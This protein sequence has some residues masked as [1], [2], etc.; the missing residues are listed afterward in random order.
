MTLN[1][2][3]SHH[4]GF[5]LI[6]ALMGVIAGLFVRRWTDLGR[7]IS[8]LHERVLLAVPVFRRTLAVHESSGWPPERLGNEFIALQQA[9]LAK[10]RAL[11]PYIVK[12]EEV[13]REFTVVRQAVEAFEARAPALAAVTA[14]LQG[15]ERVY[16]TLDA[17]VDGMPPP[18]DGDVP[19]SPRPAPLLAAAATLAGTD[20][21]LEM[22]ETARSGI[23]AQRAFLESWAK[24]F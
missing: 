21:S 11:R 15:L 17:R 6:A 9:T 7:P 19:V 24:P 12:N 13:E 23:A 5:F 8:L 4:I 18:F 14:E 3:A 10:V 2:H 22:L 1:V 20:L 16:G